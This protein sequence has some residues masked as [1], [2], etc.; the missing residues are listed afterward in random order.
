MS[1]A[2]PRRSRLGKGR[3]ARSPQAALLAFLLLPAPCL[4]AG[5]GAALDAAGPDGRPGTDRLETSRLFYTADERRTGRVAGRVE[6]LVDGDRDGDEV[7]VRT[8]DGAVDERQSDVVGEP[9]PAAEAGEVGAAADVP[10]PAAK[11]GSAA[12]RFQAM[13]Q[14]G[15]RVRV[16]VGD[17]PCRDDGRGAS[18]VCDGL[19]ERVVALRLDVGNRTLVAT[20]DDGHRRSFPVGSAI[21][22]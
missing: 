9:S 11:T 22:R 15:E 4:T 6:R 10:G 5:E 17:R 7:P 21:R 20:F 18:L 3:R 13:L 14:I 2:N 19:S 16:V 12:V 8:D 1:R